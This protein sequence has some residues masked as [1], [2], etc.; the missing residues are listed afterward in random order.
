MVF[1]EFPPA[2]AALLPP[3]RREMRSR[4]GVQQNQFRPVP[5]RPCLKYPLHTIAGQPGRQQ[6]RLRQPSPRGFPRFAKQ[7]RGHGETAVTAQTGMKPRF[8]EF[9]EIVRSKLFGGHHGGPPLIAD[10]G[11]VHHLK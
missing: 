1:V 6:R 5:P 9:V 2:I 7:S 10:R 8:V 3:P 11:N 4:R